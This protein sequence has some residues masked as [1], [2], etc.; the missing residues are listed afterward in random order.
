VERAFDRGINYLYWGSA[1]RD[2]FADGIR[3][4]AKRKRED[5]V[6]VVQTYT[7]AASMMRGSLE[8]ALHALD[9]EYTDLLLLGWWQSP[10]PPRI[11]DAALALRES[12]K[13]R[14][15]MISCHHRPA[16]ASYVADPTYGAIMVRYSAAHPGA[17]DEVFPHLPR[18]R[19]PG[20]VAYTATRWGS[21]MDPT[22]VPRGEPVPR[23]SDCYRFALT[24]PAVDV[25]LCGPADGQELD[26]AMAA[27]DRGPMSA[28]EIAWMKRVGT[29]VKNVV[30]GAGSRIVRT[31]DRI[32]SLMR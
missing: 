11:L 29:H 5:L 20:V 23:A 4:V 31:L 2:A 15:I 7:R 26:E 10:P 17:E 24:H 1:R 18:A 21:L 32:S 3:A 12:G 16:F 25:T 13:A 28:D 27:L 19:R 8:G 22:K 30:P 14:H 9:V 6:L